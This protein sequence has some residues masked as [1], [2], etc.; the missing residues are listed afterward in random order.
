MVTSEDMGKREVSSTIPLAPDEGPKQMQGR[1]Q[2]ILIAFTVMTLPMLIFSSLLLGLVFHYRITQNNFTSS[3]LAFDSNQND[4]GVYFV[5]ISATT[6]ITVASWSSTLAPILVGFGVALVSYPVAKGLLTASENHE[7]AQLPTPFQLSLIVR[8]ISSGSYSA[9]WSWLMYSFGWRGRREQQGRA[10]KSP[11]D[12]IDPR[13][14]L[15]VR[16]FSVSRNITE[17]LV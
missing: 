15:K 12:R 17:L 5:R 11:T 4:P 10:I 7:V 2:E 8:M 14:R 9:L 3:D 16:G 1:I 6:F 13:H